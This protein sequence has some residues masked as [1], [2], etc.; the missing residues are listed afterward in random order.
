MGKTINLLKIVT[1]IV[2]KIIIKKTVIIL[3]HKCLLR[4]LHIIKV[5]HQVNLSLNNHNV[6]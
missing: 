3:Q 4:L 1:A 5:D 2:S 6:Q